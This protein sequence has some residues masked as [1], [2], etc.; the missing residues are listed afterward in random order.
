[1]KMLD[2]NYIVT[3]GYVPFHLRGRMRMDDLVSV[4]R[5]IHTSE[6]FASRKR[7][8][9]LIWCRRGRHWLFLR[10]A[11]ALPPHRD[12][13][14]YRHSQKPTLAGSNTA[15]P[16]DERL[17]ATECIGMAVNG[18]A[19]HSNTYSRCDRDDGTLEFFHSFR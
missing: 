10:L 12:P 6:G 8:R 5:A 4:H 2:S 11:S 1:M 14:H 17:F 13:V 18:V 9:W 15:F 19:V 7:I 3:A 16:Q